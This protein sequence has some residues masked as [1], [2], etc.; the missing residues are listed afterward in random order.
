V[1]MLP[2]AIAQ[3]PAAPAAPNAPAG[4]AAAAP[5]AAPAHPFPPVNPK[6]F[7]ANTPTVETVN[8]F[9][10]QLWGFDQNRIWSVAAILSTNAPGVSKIVVFVADKTQPKT[11]Q[12]VFFTTPDGKHAIADNV[13]DFGATPF[14]EKRKVLQDRADGPARGAA[15][16]GL[17]L[18]EFSD[19]QCP[20]CKEAA[21]ILDQLATDFPQARVVFENFP[22]VDIHPQA[23]HAAAVGV[24]V[25]KT[26]GDEAFF[27]YA[28]AVFDTQAALTPAEE[29]AT[30]DAA[31]AKAG[32]DPATVLTCSKTLA[33]TDNVN[34]STQL[35]K[36]L[37]VDSTPALFI[38]GFPIPI[39]GVPYE[40]L[41]K[42]IA[43][44]ANEDGVPV[45]VQP[46]LKTL[47]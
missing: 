42:I 44:R 20:H 17:M 28:Q 30:I 12:T 32:A 5:Q 47:K 43:F 6:F 3:A 22:L 41:K 4:T 10:K 14:A 25:R 8:A 46:S 19:L 13:I 40:L 9:L 23:F 39:N 26:K 29:N 21:P 18:V 2:I 15:G 37:G 38:N 34:A 36:D 24:C 1:S 35:A 16:K 31:I 27:K 33:T 45:S 11:Q 7:T